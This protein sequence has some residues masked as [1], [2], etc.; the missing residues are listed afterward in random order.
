[1]T[2]S[3]RYLS[4]DL[5]FSTCPEGTGGTGLAK[6]FLAKDHMTSGEWHKLAMLGQLS[7]VLA[8]VTCSP[9]P[10]SFGF[11]PELSV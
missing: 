1:M 11:S 5:S 3:K 10:S 6:D 7:G 2:L 9:L 4:L 8:K